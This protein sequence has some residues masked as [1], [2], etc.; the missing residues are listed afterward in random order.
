MR[1]IKRGKFAVVICCNLMA[2]VLL[3]KVGEGGLYVVKFRAKKLE[4]QW[5]WGQVQQAV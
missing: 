4:K 1:G 3:G 5:P 2:Y